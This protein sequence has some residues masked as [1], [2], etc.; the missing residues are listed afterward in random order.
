MKIVGINSSHDTSLC[1][2]DTETKSLDFMH[3]EDRFRRHKY[4]SPSHVPTIDGEP[5]PQYH[6]DTLTCIYKG[7]VEVPDKLV[8]ASY[9]RRSQNIELD[10]DKLLRDRALSIEIAQ[11]IKEEPFNNVR[12][13]AFQDKYADVIKGSGAGGINEEMQ[14]HDSFANQFQGL[15]NYYFW[16][17]HHLYH[18]YCGYHLSPYIADGETAIAIVWDGGGA[19]LGW[20]RGWDGYQ[21]IESIYRMEHGKVAQ[22]QWVLSSNHRFLGDLKGEHF[23]NQMDGELDYTGA[24]IIETIDGVDYEYTSRASN[25]MDFSNMSHALGCDD[26]GRAAGKVMGMASYGVVG[27]PEQRRF[28]KF[29]LAQELE[30][31]AFEHSCNTIQK[32]I[33]LNPDC[34]NILLSGG[35]SLNCTNNYKYLSR[36]PDH[37]FYVDPIPHD[38]GTA[39]GA[40]I[41]L[42]YLLEESKID[43]PTNINGES[44]DTNGDT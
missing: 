35:Y 15:N 8:F 21:E 33:D 20:D 23:P 3:E 44:D 7:G 5:D 42:E 9:D 22:R 25:G 11:Y 17:E 28:N 4:W 38:G 2:Y 1:Q 10:S 24:N 32:A 19:R 40:C 37:Q 31:H 41:H 30:L 34:K 12:M 29:A 13:N 36:F 14:I 6:P 39:F 26:F 43:E 18:A 16:Y 27:T